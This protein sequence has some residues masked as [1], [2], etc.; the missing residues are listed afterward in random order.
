MSTPIPERIPR[1]N[2]LWAIERSAERDDAIG[3]TARQSIAGEGCAILGCGENDLVKCRICP[4]HYCRRHLQFH[5]HV[6]PR[7]GDRR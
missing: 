3:E 4:A 2:P 1:P 5:F 7:G 6:R